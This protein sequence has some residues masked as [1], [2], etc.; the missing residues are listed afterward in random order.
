MLNSELPGDREDDRL[1][2]YRI[3]DVVGKAEVWLRLHRMAKT[4]ILKGYAIEILVW[5]AAY[6]SVSVPE[7]AKIWNWRNQMVLHFFVVFQ[8]HQLIDRRLVATDVG[9]EYRYTIAA[10]VTVED[11]LNAFIISWGPS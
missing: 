11:I 9:S 1:R 3:E 4:G 6:G 10:D 5:L 8:D 7:L 2:D